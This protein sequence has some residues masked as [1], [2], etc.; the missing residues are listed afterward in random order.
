MPKTARA[1]ILAYFWISLGG[2]LLHIRLHPPLENIYN[3]APTAVAALNAFVLPF[4][5]A[6][7]STV[8]WAWLAAVATV[9]FGSVGMAW[10]WLVAWPGPWNLDAFLLRSTLPDIVILWGKLPLAWAIVRL[11]RPHEETRGRTRCRT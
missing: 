7:P 2:L 3:W 4:L 8:A 6:R 9:I 1:L 5:F 11:V 10:H